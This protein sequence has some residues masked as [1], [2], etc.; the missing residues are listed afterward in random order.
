[1]DKKTI[2]FLGV[3][4]VILAVMLYFVGIEQV[5]SALEM[6][7]LEY[8]GIAIGIQIIAY[9]FFALRWKVLNNMVNI[10]VGVKQLIPMVLV[11]LA[12]NNITP[13]GRGGGEPVR[14]YI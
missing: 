8:I 4:L 11:G 1:M 2:F 13:S 12:V 9:Y 3:S 7:K 6:A 5:I 10:D 14:A